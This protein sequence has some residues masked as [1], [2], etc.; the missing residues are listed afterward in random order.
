MLNVSEFE[1][2]D[3]YEAREVL[4]LQSVSK[5][6]SPIS[7]ATR[8]KLYADVKDTRITEGAGYKFYAVVAEAIGAHTTLYMHKPSTSAILKR[9]S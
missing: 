8:L 1:R 3:I 5:L 6:R 2:R 7:H 4:V 9:A